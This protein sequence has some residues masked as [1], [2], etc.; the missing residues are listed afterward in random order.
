L[1][2]RCIGAASIVAKVHRDRVMTELDAAHPGYGFAEHKGYPCESH[3]KAIKK[4]GP[5]PA[6]RRSFDGVLPPG[7]WERLR[8][9]QGALFSGA[10]A[11]V[12]AE[13]DPSREEEDPFE[14]GNGQQSAHLERG[15]AGEDRAL[16]HLLAKGWTLLER[17][18]RTKMGE[19]DLV[20]CKDDVLAFVEVK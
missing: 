17:N 14:R 1:R 15:V 8:S 2:C 5:T 13:S 16:E 3:R 9:G 18:W 12:A 19:L 6:H 20:V 10:V 7:E 4:L 11:T